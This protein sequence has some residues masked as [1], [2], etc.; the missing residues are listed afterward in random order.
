M[1]DSLRLPS[2]ELHLIHIQ[3]SVGTFP[4]ASFLL[5]FLLEVREQVRKYEASHVGVVSRFMVVVERVV[6]M[7]IHV[8]T[9]EVKAD[10]ET[11]AEPGVLSH[12]SEQFAK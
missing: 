12:P 5:V 10:F 9:F 4:K 1:I 2:V 11:F 8:T 3:I 6:A 7:V